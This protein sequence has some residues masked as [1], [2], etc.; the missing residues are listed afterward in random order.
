MVVRG[1]GDFTSP[2][3]M[4]GIEAKAEKLSHQCLSVEKTRREIYP[5]R[6]SIIASGRFG[7]ERGG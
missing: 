3:K 7:R 2:G 6:L 5:S 4:L 1:L